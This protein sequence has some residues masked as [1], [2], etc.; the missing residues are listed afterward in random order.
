MAYSIRRDEL[1]GSF[2]SDSVDDLVRFM[3]VVEEG[4]V[5]IDKVNEMKGV[6]GDS[7]KQD[8]YRVFHHLYGIRSSFRRSVNNAAER[9]SSRPA[10]D[11][12]TSSITSST[13]SGKQMS[14]Q[15]D[16][17]A[18][19]YDDRVCRAQVSLKGTAR[20]HLTEDSVASELELTWRGH[21]A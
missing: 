19:T 16:S 18:V 17:H 11:Q 14:L 21:N 4:R 1:D 10:P 15:T 12:H 8:Y 3:M 7:N 2:M 9:C 5:Y 13:S 6:F 20:K